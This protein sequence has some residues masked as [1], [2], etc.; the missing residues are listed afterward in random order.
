M[1]K[2]SAGVSPLRSQGKYFQRGLQQSKITKFN[3]V[4]TQFSNVFTQKPI[5]S[6][7]DKG[8][9]SFPSMPQI[10]ISTPGVKKPLD[11]LKTHK[12]LTS[13]PDSVPPMVLETYNY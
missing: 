13:G 11:N 1:R 4:I 6:M 2:D 9:S 8:P 7:Q 3:S 5:G 12:Q 10:E